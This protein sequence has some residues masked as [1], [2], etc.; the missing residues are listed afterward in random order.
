MEGLG[1]LVVVV[2]VVLGV[3]WLFGFNFGITNDGTVTYSDCRQVITLKEGDWQTYFHSFTCDIRKTNS[4]AVMGGECVSVENDHSLF[5]SSHTCA[6]AYVYEVNP[7]TACKDNTKDGISY[8]YLGYDDMC[9]T[10]PQ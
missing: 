9:Y 10:V 1:A 4:G 6:T 8:P 2:L 5:S 3:A 7:S